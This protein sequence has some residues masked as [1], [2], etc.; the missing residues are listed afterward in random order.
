MV[1]NSRVV[2]VFMLHMASISYVCRLYKVVQCGY[3]S[4][5]VPPPPPINFCSPILARQIRYTH[6]IGIFFF[7][8]YDMLLCTDHKYAKI[9]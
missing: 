7:R 3:W 1:V 2:P 9:K 8:Y 4:I 5:A 6:R